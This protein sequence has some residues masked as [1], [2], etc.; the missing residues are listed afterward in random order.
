M[1]NLFHFH[2]INGQLQ[3]RKLVKKPDIHVVDSDDTCSF[4]HQSDRLWKIVLRSETEKKDVHHLHAG[5]PGTSLHLSIV[6]CSA[7]QHAMLFS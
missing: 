5:V 7:I 4:S 2:V 6:K 1:D 3:K